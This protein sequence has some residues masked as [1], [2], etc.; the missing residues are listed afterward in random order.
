[1]KWVNLISAGWL[2]ALLAVA[3]AQYDQAKAAYQRTDYDAAIR[4]LSPAAGKDA[5]DWALL[6]MS[7]FG[8]AD[9]KRSAEAFEKAVQLE[10]RNSEYINWLGKAWGRRAESA[11]PFM[12]PTYASRARTQFEKAVMLDPANKEALNNLFD[13]YLEAP[14]FLGGGFN[15][16]QALVDKISRLDPAEGHYAQAQ[17]ADKRKQFDE[18]EQQLRRALELAPRQ[19]GRVIDLAKYLSK[20]G[21]IQESEAAFAQAENIAPD[22]P[23]IL[24][25]RA[26]TY[27]RDKR[28]LGQARELLKRYLSSKLTADDPPREKAEELLRKAGA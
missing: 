16:A 4:L 23:R 17:L 28:N 20:R 26:E 5:A 25:E 15:R 21:R 27:V 1:M 2:T 8:K 14:G 13:Y 11:S 6:G 12:A 3:S 24:Y 19:V 7:Y 22:N 10:P 18:A 9:Y